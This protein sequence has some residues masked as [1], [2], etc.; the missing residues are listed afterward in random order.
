MESNVLVDPNRKK[1]KKHTL[2]AKMVGKNPNEPERFIS[3]KFL[4][5]NATPRSPSK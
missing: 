2:E 3:N 1:G 4:E 5:G